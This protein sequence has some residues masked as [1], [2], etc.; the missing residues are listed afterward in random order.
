MNAMG[1]LCGLWGCGRRRRRGGTRRKSFDGGTA[2]NG[3]CAAH[4]SRGGQR[5]LARYSLSCV[6]RGGYRHLDR[7][8]LAASGA[9]PERTVPRPTSGWQARKRTS[10]MPRSPPGLYLDS[11]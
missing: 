4:Q 6:C 2:A 3:A 11:R 9:L 8:V 1:G 5:A 7:R 10:G